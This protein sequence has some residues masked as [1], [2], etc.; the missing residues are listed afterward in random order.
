MAFSILWDEPLLQRKRKRKTGRDADEEPDYP[1]YVKG[2]A[3]KR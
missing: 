2:P 1:Y 3:S